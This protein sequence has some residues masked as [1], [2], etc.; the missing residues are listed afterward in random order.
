MLVSFSLFLLSLIFILL[1]LISLPPSI[2]LL[3]PSLLLFVYLHPLHVSSL[4]DS[5]FSPPPLSLSLIALSR[6]SLLLFVYLHP[7]HVSSLLDSSP[8]S[9]LPPFHSLYLSLIDLP[10]PSLSLPCLLPLSYFLF[11]STPYMCPLCLI[12]LYI[13]PSS[14]PSFSHCS[15]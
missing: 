12:L 5:S 14:P 10:K 1:T 2:C 7:L 3:P 9:L 15:P 8:F 11:I 6:P 13:I 4:L